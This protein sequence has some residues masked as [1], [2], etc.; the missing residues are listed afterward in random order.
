M[1]FKSWKW[2]RIIQNLNPR[3]STIVLYAFRYK[4]EDI[5]Q[6]TT[7]QNESLYRD[8]NLS[9]FQDHF[10]TKDINISGANFSS[11]GQKDLKLGQCLDMDAMTSPSKFGHITWPTLDFMSCSVVKIANLWDIN[12]KFL[13]FISNVNINNPA[14]FREI[15]I[16]K[17]CICKIR[18]FRD[19]FL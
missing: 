8:V 3:H 11:T 19:F 9:W 2:P 14:K 7:C 17:N 18:D 12:L 10:L 6:P 15:N 1:Q 4:F 13:G 5:F 16:P